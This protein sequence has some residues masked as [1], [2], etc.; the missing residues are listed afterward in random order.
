MYLWCV[1]VCLRVRAHV[2]KRET[3]TLCF[4][5]GSSTGVAVISDSHLSLETLGIETCAHPAVAGLGQTSIF[6]GL[7]EGATWASCFSLY[8]GFAISLVSALTWSY[9]KFPQ[10]PW[11]SGLSIPYLPDFS[12]LKHLIKKISNLYKSTQNK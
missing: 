1:C 7:V 5:S 10:V 3:V 12:G 11:D 6:G 8:R 9:F 4:L 2:T